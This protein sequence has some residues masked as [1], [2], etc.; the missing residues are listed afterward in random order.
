MAPHHFPE[1]VMGWLV[2]IVVLIIA[3]IVA[4]VLLNRYYRKATREVALVRT[5][6]GG[7]RVVLDGGCIA[8]PFLHKVTEINM[9]TSKLE[10]DRAGEK[11]IITLDRLRVDAGVEFYVRVQG[12]ADGVSTAAQA[13]AG[14]TFRAPELAD[15]LE[16]KLVDAMLCVAAQYT[17]D[18]LQDQRAEYC[19]EVAAMLTDNLSQN[20]LVLE[21]VSLTRLDQTPF[22]ALDE[23]N[24]FNALGMR[25]LSEIIAVNKK[26]RAVIEADAD[27]AVRQSQLEATKRKLKI[28]QEEEET[29]IEQ[30]REVDITRAQSQADVAERQAQSE[31]RR[32]AARIAREREVRQLEITR[33][34]MLR[35]QALDSELDV[36]T[37]QA[38]NAVA[39]AAK[40]IEEYAAEV[41]VKD[42]KAREVE[43]EERIKTAQEAAAA[44][45]DKL[46]AL[47][48]A[49]ER[50]EVADTRVQSEAGTLTAMARAEANA[51]MEKAAAQKS[52]LLAK[53]EGTAALIRAENQHSNELIRM[54]LDQARLNALP[55]V[56]EKM[57]KPA[58]KIES[59]RINQITGLDA[60]RGPPAVMG[61]GGGSSAVNDVVDGV[62]NLA[63]QLPAVRKLGEEVGLNIAAGTRGVTAPLAATGT[64]DTPTEDDAKS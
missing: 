24:A 30:Q 60:G 5:G 4:I 41:A 29:I 48:R 21:S 20:G 28:S 51:I 18:N 56:V 34:R 57:L 8:L 12:D 36:G 49:A 17:M 33:D 7:Q 2:A 38:D 42:A 11:S 3:A 62:L 50:A 59:I 27:V 13:L 63:L 44:E 23:N 53:A 58:E 19:A 40:R 22:H 14:K 47:I 64:D 16:G 45:R 52:D 55:E 61:G 9:R 54:K 46:L 35:R 15:T 26:A 39:L 31:Q 6:A 43:A 10:I 32:E 1:A 25:R 37:A